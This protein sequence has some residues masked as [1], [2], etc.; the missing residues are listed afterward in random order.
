[1]KK[2][3]SLNFRLVVIPLLVVILGVTA[4]AG[5][6]FYLVRDQIFAD[7]EREGYSRAED[8][9]QRIEDSIISI[10]T[11]ESLLEEE[12]LNTATVV[13]R[14]LDTLDNTRLEEIAEDLGVYAINVFDTNGEVVFSNLETNREGT[15]APPEHVI[16]EMMNDNIP[17]YIEE[18]RASQGEDSDNAEHF[19]F[20][21]LLND[22]NGVIQVGIEADVI[23]DLTES[24]SHQSIVEGL[25]LDE[26][27][28]YV[29]F[30]DLDMQVT[31]HSDKERVGVD[32][33]SDD[34]IKKAILEQERTAE[35][36]LYT[37]D[38]IP[39]YDV[40]VPVVIDDEAIGALNIGFSMD[41][42]NNTVGSFLMLIMIIAVL[43]IIILGATL[44][45]FSNNSV[46]KLKK[47]KNY[48]KQLGK[49]D[50]KTEIDASLLKDKSELG[51]I[52]EELN[53]TQH[54]I[55]KIISDIIESSRSLAESS[56]VLDGTSENFSHSS[57]EVTKSVEQIAHSASEQAEETQKGASNIQNLGRIMEQ[58]KENMEV[59]NESAR[60]IS[61]V[62]DDGITTVTALVENA[63][64]S[65][66]ATQNVS[67]L[68]NKTNDSAITITEA[69]QKIGDI[70]GQTN[71]LALN[72]SIEA[73]RAG[74]AGKGFAVV[75]DEIRKLAEQSTSF[76][77]EITNVISTLSEESQM[78]VSTVKELERTMTT[79]LE[80]VEQTNAKFE[81]IASALNEMEEIITDVN[82]SS[83]EIDQKRK[84]IADIIENLSAISEEN[85]ASSEE[86]SASMQSQASSIEEIS[87]SSENLSELAAKMKEKVEQFII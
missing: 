6:S 48:V 74:E 57:E 8:Y 73:A 17:Q 16:F 10:E 76:S 37:E 83:E 40:I 3:N 80:S 70:A 4:I 61:E 11:I 82:A 25:A 85:A 67:Q 77:E 42:I 20:G 33:E 84:A 47:V 27:I 45:Y 87:Q 39:V 52:A 68:I 38:E 46:K 22:N 64:G 51:E 31:A 15:Q 62:K 21:Y 75:A 60:R 36:I 18:V 53:R 35:Q 59:L 86:V 1:M 14:E 13:N 78:G 26:E 28:E 71:L 49:G 66:K 69:I 30:A 5:M 50:L 34:G 23:N 54:S 19:K 56:K 65:E 12:I 81:S 2:V 63:Q 29:Y 72:A 24:S 55:K 32:I 58:N 41:R 79:Q 43:V 44:I 9:I 7:M